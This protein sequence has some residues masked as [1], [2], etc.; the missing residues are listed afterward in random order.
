MIHYSEISET[1]LSWYGRFARSMPWRGIQDPYR[2]WVSETMLQQT[3]HQKPDKTSE[4]RKKNEEK[5]RKQR[6][7][8]MVRGCLF[9]IKALYYIVLLALNPFEC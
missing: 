6:K 3:N 1:L 5:E 2:T 4:N 8:V 9:S 7:N